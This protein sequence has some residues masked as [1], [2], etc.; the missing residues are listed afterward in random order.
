MKILT[1]E[2]KTLIRD[3]IKKYKM[4]GAHARGFARWMIGVFTADRREI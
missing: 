4:T 2:Q 3:Q 1:N